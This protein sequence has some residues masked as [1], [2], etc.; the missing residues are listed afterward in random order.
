MILRIHV[1]SGSPASLAI[2]LAMT[3][4]GRHSLTW[5][6]GSLLAGCMFATVTCYVRNC[7]R[8]VVS[9]GGLAGW[10]R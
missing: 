3:R 10:V 4:S 8:D 9:F 6:T 2:R 1:V 7:K 5:W